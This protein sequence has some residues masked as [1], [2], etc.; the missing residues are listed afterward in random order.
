MVIAF[1]LFQEIES[2]K[3]DSQAE[4]LQVFKKLNC[5]WDLNP[6]LQYPSGFEVSAIVSAQARC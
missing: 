3:T 1:I 5:R 6:C 4:L 2:C